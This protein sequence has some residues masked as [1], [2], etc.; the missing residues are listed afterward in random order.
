MAH[1]VIYFSVSV[2]S[3]LLSAAEDQTVRLLL[4]FIIF[5]FKW[6]LPYSCPDTTLNVCTQRFFL[7]SVTLLFISLHP[8][9]FFFFFNGVTIFLLFILHRFYDFK[10]PV[11]NIGLDL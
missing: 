11:C 3:F 10:G 9:F 2:L 1:G 8:L 6:N 7:L 4:L 5:P